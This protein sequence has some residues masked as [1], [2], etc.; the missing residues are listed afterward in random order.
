MIK[1]LIGNYNFT[2]HWVTIKN[3]IYEF[4]KGTLKD[5]IDWCDLYNVDPE[6]ESRYNTIR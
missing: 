1:Y 5:N 4:S 6:D 2:H 3:T